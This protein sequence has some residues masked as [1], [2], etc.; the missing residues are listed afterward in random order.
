M[1]LKTN[2]DKSTEHI[3]DKLSNE[4]DSVICI[5]GG[6]LFKIRERKISVH[7]ETLISLLLSKSIKEL[8]HHLVVASEAE[9][10]ELKFDIL[11]L[12]DCL[13]CR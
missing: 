2:S 7:A 6:L 3:L 12:S 9:G 13:V 5:N 8:T 10:T 1:E 11:C 4:N